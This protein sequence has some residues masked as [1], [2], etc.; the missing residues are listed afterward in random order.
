MQFCFLIESFSS[1]DFDRTH[2][3]G[4]KY[5]EV[6]SFLLCNVAKYMNSNVSQ[7]IEQGS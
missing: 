2:I 6:S 1:Y 5:T 3:K 7:P 4:L